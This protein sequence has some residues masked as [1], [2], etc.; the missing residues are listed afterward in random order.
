VTSTGS[1]GVELEQTV[2]GDIRA[3]TGSGGVKIATPAK[4][5]FDLRAH[6]G[7]GQITVDRPMTIRGT[8]GH[9]DLQAKVGGGGSAI[10][11]VNTGSGSIHIQ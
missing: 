6:T 8:I 2:A 7:S 5:G 1:G 3:H 9:H 11:D 10:V 4:T